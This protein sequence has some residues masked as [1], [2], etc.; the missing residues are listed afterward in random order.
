MILSNIK[1]YPL[2]GGYFLNFYKVN[3]SNCF[4][5]RT[6]ILNFINILM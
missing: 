2:A 4:T 6:H 1:N 3:E 5:I